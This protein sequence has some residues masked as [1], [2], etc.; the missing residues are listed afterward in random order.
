MILITVSVRAGVGEIDW[1]KRKGVWFETQLRVPP[2]RAR[3]GNFP[4]YSECFGRI[5]NVRVC[6]PVNLKTHMLILDKKQL[7]Y[8]AE[9]HT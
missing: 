6:Q 4:K 8:L 7:C 3:R 9:N 5:L 2:S 1:T